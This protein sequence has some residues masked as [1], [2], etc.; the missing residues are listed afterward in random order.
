MAVYKDG[1]KWRVIYRYTNYMGE[2]KQTQKRGFVTKREAVVWEHEVMLRSESK[3]VKNLENGETDIEDLK[4]DL[5]TVFKTINIK[6][7]IKS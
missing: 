5:Q 7:E 1:D 2:R 6:E 3:L 4:A